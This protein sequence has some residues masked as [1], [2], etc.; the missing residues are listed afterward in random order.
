MNYNNLTSSVLSIGQTLKIPS[1]NVEEE[2][3]TVEYITYTVKKGDSLYSIAR[4]YGVSVNDIMS[5]NNLNSSLLS[6]GQT[7]KIP[8]AEETTITYT[9]KSGDTLYEIAQSYNTTVNSIKQ[10]NNLT[11]N[12]LRIGQ[13][14]VI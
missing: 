7:L 4:T 10:K 6:I 3:E 9:V 14:L 2:Q 12:T 11:S 1:Q 13:T 8:V 5:L